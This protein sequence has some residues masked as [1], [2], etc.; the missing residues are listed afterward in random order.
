MVL[1]EKRPCPPEGG[2]RSTGLVCSKRNK[3][4]NV[5]GWL[6]TRI[7]RKKYRI[8]VEVDGKVLG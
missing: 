6:V 2:A 1:G 5:N 8:K 7:E 4:K 3:Q